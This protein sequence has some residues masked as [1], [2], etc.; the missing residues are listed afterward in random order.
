M[1]ASCTLEV[2][3]EGLD[4]QDHPHYKPSLSPANNRNSKLVDPSTKGSQG[5]RM[6][7]WGQLGLHTHRGMEDLHFSYSFCTKTSII[8]LTGE[9]AWITHSRLLSPTFEAHGLHGLPETLTAHVQPGFPDQTVEV[10]AAS[11]RRTLAELP[12]VPPVELLVTHLA[13]LHLANKGKRQV[14]LLRK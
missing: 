8:R 1:P 7:L 6:D 14:S 4:A 5:R 3:T 2:W 12:W 10:K 9:T 11:T 13:C